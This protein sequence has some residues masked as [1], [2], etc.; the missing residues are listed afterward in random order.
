MK[1]A[2]TGGAGF[3]G[4]S[5]VNEFCSSDDE[6]LVLD[7]RLPRWRLADGV[8]SLTVDVTDR[9]AMTR[10]L[11][12]FDVV[13]HAAFAPP[14][15]PAKEQRRVNVGGVSAVVEAA[16]DAGVRRVVIV[17]STIVDR[18]LPSFAF[19]AGWQTHRLAT[20]AK[21]R[22]RGEEIALGHGAVSV[23]IARPRT[24]AGAGAVGPFALQFRN[25]ANDRP[26]VLLGTGAAAYQLLHV[27]D[28]AAGLAALARSE[29]RIVLAFGS[30]SVLPLREEIASLIDHAQ[31]RSAI[32]GAPLRLGRA[33]V[34][35]APSFGVRPV[36]EMYD[37]MVDERAVVV[38]NGPAR[39]AI[40]WAPRWS[41]LETIID[42]FDWFRS[43]PHVASNHPVPR[44]HAVGLRLLAPLLRSLDEKG[45]GADNSSN[46]ER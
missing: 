22:R 25:I 29:A 3:L 19:P 10:A 34:R 16:A 24:L 6:T 27:N 14:Y 43:Q 32:V 4:Q 15:A 35:C 36:S 13:V 8:A 23:A 44:A 46:Q 20:Y 28:F 40:G 11:R 38:D 31:S 5:L 2:I 7:R 21:T 41:N 1:V 18:T 9:P 42:A 39:H 17:S 45:S 26:V 30:R 33:I 37:A 12:G